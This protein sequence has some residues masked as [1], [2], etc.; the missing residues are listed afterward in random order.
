MKKISIVLAMLLFGMKAQAQCEADTVHKNEFSFSILPMAVILAGSDPE[1]RMNNFNLSYKRYMKKGLVLRTALVYFPNVGKKHNDG[2]P[3]FDRIVDTMNVFRVNS[4]NGSRTQVNVGLEK[5]FTKGR[6]IHGFGTD[7]WVNSEKNSQQIN[8]WWESQKADPNSASNT[9]P[10]WNQKNNVDS[11]TNYTQTKT[12]GVGLQLFYSA[13]FR[14][15][16]RFYLSCTAGP[17]FNLGFTNVYAASS[18]RKNAVG[19]K[20]ASIDFNLLISDVSLAYRF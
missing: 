3:V 16:K 12:T 11:L 1:G 13:R 19:M 8:Y 20:W 5:V 15:S 6:M 17:H 9:S 4:N 14:M 2:N 10:Y 18:N 7:L